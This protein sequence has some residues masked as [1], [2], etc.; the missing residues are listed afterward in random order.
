LQE[1]GVVLD[2]L[3]EWKLKTYAGVNEVTPEVIR[4]LEDAING[5]I[6]PEIKQQA[7]T[8]VISPADTKVHN[9]VAPNINSGD[10]ADLSSEVKPAFM[11]LLNKLDSEGL[12]FK[13]FEV[14][15][16]QERQE[17]LYRQ[18][19]TDKELIDVG[20]D[21]N[22]P[23]PKGNKK[24]TWTLH[25]NHASGRAVDFV[26]D[27]EHP[28]W[29]EFGSRPSG[30]WDTKTS[31]IMDVWKRLGELASEAGLIWG[32][33]WSKPDYPH[34]EAPRRRNRRPVANSTFPL[35]KEAIQ[36]L[37]HANGLSFNN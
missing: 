7:P 25:S 4:R 19:R 29:E 26:L 8:R 27:V 9:K 1:D 15:R 16:S 28:Y 3:I 24:V 20:I 5:V 6:A 14:R 31:G 22:G 37:V 12:P 18:G 10:I 30:P 21:P 33:R 2:P 13:V 23:R 36:V 11:S 32:G 35:T 17:Y 34:V